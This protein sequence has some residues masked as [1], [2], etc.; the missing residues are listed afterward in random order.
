MALSARPRLE[1]WGEGRGLLGVVVA[2]AE[3]THESRGPE[4]QGARA[5]MSKDQTKVS[6]VAQKRRTCSP[7]LGG[8]SVLG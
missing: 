2:A 5:L 4:C 1:N 7:C 8:P 6:S 3:R